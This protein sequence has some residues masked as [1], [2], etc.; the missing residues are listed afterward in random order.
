MSTNGF[1][2]WAG[3]AWI[4]PLG[5]LVLFVLCAAPVQAGDCA[6]RVPPPNGSDDTAVLQAAL[7]RCVRH[8]PGCTVQ[9]AAG[10]YL[11]RQLLAYGFRGT[12]KGRGR[13]ETVIEA[14]SGLH[15]DSWIEESDTY[16]PPSADHPWPSLILFVD[17][18]IRVSDLA[19]RIPHVPATEPYF[20][21]PGWQVAALI[22]AIRFMGRPHADASVER[23]AIEGREDPGDM[24][25]FGF[26]VANGVAYVGE[27]PKATGIPFDYYPITGRLT[28]RAS[29]FESV[30]AG[31]YPGIVKD[32]QVAIGGSP[33]AG[34]VFENVAVGTDLESLES[35]TVEVSH[36]RVSGARWAA[37]WA[38]PWCCGFLPTKPSRFSIRDNQLNPAGESAEGIL[39][40]DDPASPWIRAHVAYNTVEAQDIG[41]G[42]I[43]AYNTRGIKIHHN[44]ISGNGADAIGIWNG[45]GALVVKNDLRDFHADFTADYGRAQIVLDGTTSHSVVV[46][47]S[48]TDTVLD[49]GQGN[50]LI[51]CQAVTP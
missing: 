12:L 42:G 14:L 5:F 7:D 16:W 43:S 33:S 41:Y 20:L 22:D 31:V 18:D 38:V 36:N 21:A 35:S 8:G 29:R 3:R 37:A 1:P 49:Q 32:G 51:G 27:F 13:H 11:T 9:L 44:R 4:G 2:R 39:L 47:K 40:L 50:R 23:V 30:A 17:G 25:L 28:V 24:G 6:V 34:N 19:V 26:N 48:P 15:V 45:R 10:R 46:C